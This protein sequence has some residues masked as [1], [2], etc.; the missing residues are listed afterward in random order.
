MLIFQIVTSCPLSVPSRSSRCPRL[1]TLLSGLLMHQTLFHTS[2]CRQVLSMAC[3]WQIFCRQSKLVG[4]VHTMHFLVCKHCSCLVFK[5]AN[6]W[7]PRSNI[8]KP[9]KNIYIDIFV[10]NGE[11]KINFCLFC[12]FINHIKTVQVEAK[13]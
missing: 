6:R 2:N 13:K 4:P 3:A 9:G 8:C 11:L 10:L 7:H 5:T 12:K 1:N